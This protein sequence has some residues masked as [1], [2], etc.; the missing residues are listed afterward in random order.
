[1]CLNPRILCLCSSECKDLWRSSGNS[2]WCPS[3][4]TVRAQDPQV[5]RARDAGSAS[6]SPAAEQSPDQGD[7]ITCFSHL[8][9]VQN[10]L[11]FSVIGHVVGASRGNTE[12]G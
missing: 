2:L 1:M 4:A 12:E 5:V 6:P 10:N 9:E 8:T 7:T 11:S 3:S